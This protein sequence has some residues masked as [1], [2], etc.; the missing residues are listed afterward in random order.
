M[1]ISYYVQCENRN[2]VSINVLVSQSVTL[3]IM[4]KILTDT[5]FSKSLKFSKIHYPVSKSD[6][7]VTSLLLTVAI[8]LWFP[9]VLQALIDFLAKIVIIYKVK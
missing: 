9:I 7:K 3:L 5:K 1:A 8:V 4:L 6:N 2:R